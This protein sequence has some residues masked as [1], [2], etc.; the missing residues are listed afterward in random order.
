MTLQEA[1]KN[2]IDLRNGI[3]HCLRIEHEKW[4]T[5]GWNAALNNQWVSVE[6][7]KPKPKLLKYRVLAWIGNPIDGYAKV[8]TIYPE[9]EG[10]SFIG[11]NVTFWK[12]MH[13]PKQ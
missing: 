9:N 3:D 12:H 5:A 1:I 4:F 13:S 11:Y 7:D 6:E 2:D 8:L 10:D